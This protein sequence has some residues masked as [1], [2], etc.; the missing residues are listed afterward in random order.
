MS[1]QEYTPFFSL[2]SGDDLSLMNLPDS[3]ANDSSQTKLLEKSRALNERYEKW[4]EENLKTE[5]MLAIKHDVSEKMPKFDL[6]IIDKQS[7]TLL[8]YVNSVI[9]KDNANQVFTL[10][11]EL[12]NNQGFNA[13][14][15]DSV[16]HFQQLMSKVN[17]T[18]EIPEFTYVLEM[19]GILS[20]TNFKHVQGNKL[21]MQINPADL[22]FSDFEVFAESRLTNS[23]LFYLT[24]FIVLLAI[25]LLIY[26]A[27]RNKK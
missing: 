20:D 4:L 2:L 26:S 22:F 9:E 16:T 17:K 1:E 18:Y 27:F 10:L 13:I 12:N 3:I 15:N 23:Y 19:P 25:G 7:D 8:S 5:I 24:G 14:P 11:A 6:R 21:S